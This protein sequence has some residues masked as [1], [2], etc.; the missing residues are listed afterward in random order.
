MQICRM[1]M[2]YNVRQISISSFSQTVYVSESVIL[3]TFCKNS[4]YI[5]KYSIKINLYY[6]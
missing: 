4:V 5:L 6:K 1:Y 2:Q 3:M